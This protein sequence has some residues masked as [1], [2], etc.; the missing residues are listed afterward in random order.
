LLFLTVMPVHGE[1]NDFF[2]SWSEFFDFFGD[3]N[4]GLVMFPSLLIPTGGK[5]EGMGTAFTAVA[6]DSGL[7][8]ANPA[9]SSTLSQPKLAFHHHNW[10]SDSAVETITFV[11]SRNRLGF[12][13]GVKL[14]YSPFT[15][16][17]GSGERISTGYFSEVLITANGSMSLVD[18]PDRFNLA[19]GVN[20]KG[21][22]RH[23]SEAIAGDQS[24]V[25]L[26]LDVGILTRFR[27]PTFSPVKTTNAAFG[28]ALKNLAPMVYPMEYPVPTILSAGIAYSPTRALLLSLDANL[29]ISFDSG[30][31]PAAQFDL[32]GGLELRVTRFLAFHSGLHFKADNPR[33]SV[34]SAIDVGRMDFILNYNV[35]LMGGLNPI[36]MFSATV[37]LDL[38]DTR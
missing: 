21:I 13:A 16:Y 10:I 19:V 32:A 27:L 37:A 9:G 38:G 3:S 31:F 26:P 33:V 30:A 20:V 5:Y 8:E 7:L 11:S 22:I 29:P 17:D 6:D 23:V 12:G 28:V 18:I 2:A 1:F 35:D 34:G 14:F 36:D 15:A 25:A 4:S 24:A